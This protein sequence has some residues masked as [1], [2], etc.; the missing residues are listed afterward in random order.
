MSNFSPNADHALD[1][2]PAKLMARSMTKTYSKSFYLATKLL[3]HRVRE[4]VYAVYAFCRQ[5]DNIVDAPRNRGREL[6]ASELAQWREELQTAY[7]TGESQ[8]PVMNVF[9]DV[10]LRKGIPVD[11]PLELIAGVEMDLDFDRY[12]TFD[13]LYK[14]CYRVASVVGVM[15]TRVVG[16]SDDW[17]FV[18]AERLGIGMQLANILR[19]VEEDWRLRGK[20]Y[21]PRDEMAQFGVT[22]SEIARGSLSPN[23]RN[24][25]VH[26]VA[27]A[28]WYFEQSMEGIP[29]LS[30]DVQFAIIAASRLYRGILTAIEKNEYDVFSRRPV[31]TSYR[32]LVE[33]TRSYIRHKVISPRIVSAH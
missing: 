5:S 14:F 1:L 17:A 31:V 13:D 22:E 16:H 7:R 33:I 15:M 24:L 10:A 21:I 6:V 20:I 29:M 8:H 12:E 2:I 27:R 32:K 23:L 26:N 4:D 28:H 19:D 11:L 25:L 30:R 9:I 3:P 18:H